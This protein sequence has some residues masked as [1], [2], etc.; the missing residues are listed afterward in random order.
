MKALLGLVGLLLV[1]AIVGMLGRSQLRAVAGGEAAADMPASATVRE[2]ADAVQER[3]RA[4]VRKAIDE[5]AAR[6]ED[7]A[8]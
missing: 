4:E 5:A 2:R 6:R 3:A 8:R 7:A 1:L